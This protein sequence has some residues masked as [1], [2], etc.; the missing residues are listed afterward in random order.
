MGIRYNVLERRGREEDLRSSSQRNSNRG[1]EWIAK[2][3][4]GDDR[5]REKGVRSV[6][7]NVASREG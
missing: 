5:V 3:A 1:V 2:K 4:W 6:D 7:V